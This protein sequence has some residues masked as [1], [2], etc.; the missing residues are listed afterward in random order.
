MIPG[1]AGVLVGGYGARGELKVSSSK[2]RAVQRCSPQ[3]SACA[4]GNGG[5][6]VFIDG[7]TG[8]FDRCGGRGWTATGFLGDTSR[9]VVLGRVSGD[10]RVRALSGAG[11]GG[12]VAPGGG[13]GGCRAV[14]LPSAV[15]CVLR[16]GAGEVRDVARAGGRWADGERGGEHARVLARGVLCGGGGVRAIGDGGAVGRAAGTAGPLRLSPEVLA[17][18]EA[19]RREMPA[20]SGAQLARE[21]EAGLGVVERR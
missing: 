13:V 11:A 14:S 10:D 19:R 18:L 5:Y 4:C 8:R 20:A 17:F 6:V 1:G 9:A 12:V 2:G 15:L 3:D 21:L 7:Q 16:Q